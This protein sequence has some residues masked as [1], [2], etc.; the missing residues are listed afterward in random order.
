MLTAVFAASVIWFLTTSPSPNV[1]RII[2]IADEKITFKSRTNCIA[3][4]RNDLVQ[5]QAA[6]TGRRIGFRDGMVKE[7][8]LITGGLVE[9]SN[10]LT[11]YD[12]E[13][14]RSFGSPE[15]RPGVSKAVDGAVPK[16]LFFHRYERRIRIC[17]GKTK[18]VT[19]YSGYGSPTFE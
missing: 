13:L 4:L 10:R 17:R 16:M 2:P 1:S 19:G 14:W 6:A 12:S 11:V 18:T 8:R 7:V 15:D 9:K 3:S 5:D